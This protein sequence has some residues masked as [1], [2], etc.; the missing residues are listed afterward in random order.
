MSII[1]NHRPEVIDAQNGTQEGRPREWDQPPTDAEILEMARQAAV[2][3]GQPATDYD[4]DE[5]IVLVGP[6]A[7]L[8]DPEPVPAVVVNALALETY[9]LANDRF[10]GLIDGVQ[11]ELE[12]T[13]TAGPCAVERLSQLLRAKLQEMDQVAKVWQQNKWGQ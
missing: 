11:R 13:Q 5:D 8:Y 6:A 12:R 3:F 2:R 9:V 1:S 4:P 10:W 7:R